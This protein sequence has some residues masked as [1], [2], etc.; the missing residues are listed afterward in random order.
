MKFLEKIQN[1]PEKKRKIILWAILIVLASLML[2]F[3]TS[4]IPRRLNDFRAGRFLEQ[5]GFPKITMPQMPAL[6]A[7]EIQTIK[8][9]LNNTKTNASEETQSQEN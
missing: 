5:L 4:S 8:D 7:A 9:S 2:F 3:W 1:L 6:P